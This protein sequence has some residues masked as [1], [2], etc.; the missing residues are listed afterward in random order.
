MGLKF[1]P[2]RNKISSPARRLCGNS[3]SV[4][5]WGRGKGV[6]WNGSV[7]PMLVGQRHR[8]QFL[9]AQPPLGQVLVHERDETVVVLPLDEV[10]EF[11][12]ENVFEALR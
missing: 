4:R 1:V 2:N 3:D 9:A 6:D 5:A 7:A 12:D 8:V 10:G 11:V